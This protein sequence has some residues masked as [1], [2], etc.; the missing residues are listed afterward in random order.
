MLHVKKELKAG[1]Y[2]SYY[3]WYEWYRAGEKE[4]IK[5]I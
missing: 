4:D 3:E 2:S 5:K 1:G